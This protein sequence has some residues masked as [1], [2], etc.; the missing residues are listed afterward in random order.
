[1]RQF[2]ARWCLLPSIRTYILIDGN[3]A[4]TVREHRI[5]HERERTQANMQDQDYT[6]S[7][8]VDQTPEDAFAAINN[9]RR[10]FTFRGAEAPPFRAGAAPPSRVCSPPLA[11]FGAPLRARVTLRPS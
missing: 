10:W 2:R 5:E 7:F 8:T 9:V 6:T 11:G 1:M 3:T 4:G